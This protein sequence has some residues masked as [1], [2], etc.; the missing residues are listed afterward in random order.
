MKTEISNRLT[1]IKN[2]IATNDISKPRLNS[3]IFKLLSK[4]SI[5]NKKYDEIIALQKFEIEILKSKHIPKNIHVSTFL[6]PLPFLPSSLNPI[7][8]PLIHSPSNFQ[9]QPK[10]PIHLPHKIHPSPLLTPTSKAR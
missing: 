4:E 3:I 6:P 1:E 7:E 5:E 8:P 10:L 2:I 9:Q